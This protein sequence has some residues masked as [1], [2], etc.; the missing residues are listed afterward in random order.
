MLK[1]AT[2]P[3]L[4]VEATCPLRYLSKFWI[5]LDLTLVNCEL[6]LDLSWIKDCILIQHHNH[7]TGA[8]FQINNAKLYALVVTLSINDNTKF[9]EN[10]KPGFKRTISWNKYRSEIKTPPKNNNF[11]LSD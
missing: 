9:L 10:I 8:T 11:I 6:E 1:S 3:S 2:A 5:F 7:I 4:N